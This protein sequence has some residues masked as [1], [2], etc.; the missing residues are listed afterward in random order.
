MKAPRSLVLV[1]WVVPG[2]F[3]SLHNCSGASVLTTSPATEVSA[4]WCT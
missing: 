3:V 4:I 2:Q 1:V